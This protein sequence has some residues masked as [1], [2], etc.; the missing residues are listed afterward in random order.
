MVEPQLPLAGIL[1]YPVGDRSR[2]CR[3]I[4]LASKPLPAKIEE[5]DG[6]S[7]RD[8]AWWQLILC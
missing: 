2:G 6:E 5:N 8:E 3:L 7:L 4:A 1:D